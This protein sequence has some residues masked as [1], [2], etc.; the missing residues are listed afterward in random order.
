MEGG[1]RGEWGGDFFHRFLVPPLTHSGHKVFRTNSYFLT[2]KSNFPGLKVRESL[3][4]KK[5]KIEIIII[6]K[7]EN[8]K[9]TYGVIY[10][11]IRDILM[12]TIRKTIRRHIIRRTIIASEE[13]KSEKGN[14][15][16]EVYFQEKHRPRRAEHKFKI[17]THWRAAYE[18][19]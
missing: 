6:E 1:K 2:Y 14:F 16:Y 4:K 7:V 10:D 12:Y 8:N 19:T 17:A 13:V 5:K 9:S 15:L 3:K 11:A 18:A